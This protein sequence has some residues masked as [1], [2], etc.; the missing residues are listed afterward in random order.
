MGKDKK[1][2]YMINLVGVLV[3]FFFFVALFESGVLG[4]R[5]TYIKGICTTACYTI[6]MVAS[7]NLLVGFMG[8]FRTVDTD[9]FTVPFCNNAFRFHI[10][11]LIF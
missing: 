7:L 3:L 10:D 6:V 9:S 4:S 5:T 11:K 2:S 8:E 1:I